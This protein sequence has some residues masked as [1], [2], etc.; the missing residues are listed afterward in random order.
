MK[1]N[2]KGV[3][4]FEMVLLIG[5]IFAVS[6]MIASADFVSGAV[7]P[8]CCEQ[9]TEGGIC[10]D[11]LDP[12]EC[13]SSGK[14][15]AASC[16]ETS[17]C[18]IGCCIDDLEGTFDRNVPQKLCTG[19]N[20]RWVDDPTC[21]IQGSGLGCCVLGSDVEY[22]TS[23]RCSRL[24]DLRGVDK[25]Y[26]NLGENDCLALGELQVKGACV[27]PNDNCKFT[28]AED[29]VSLIGNEQSFYPG[30]LCSAPE[31]NTTCEKTEMTTCLDGQ[32]EVYFLDSC[33]NTA[34][35]YDSSK[36]NDDEYW[37]YFLFRGN[38]CNP[39]E[40]NADS[41]DCGACSRFLGSTCASASSE[42]FNPDMGDYFCKSTSCEYEGTTYENGESWC[43]YDGKIGEGKDVVGSR[44]WKMICSNGEV[45]LEPCA[46]YRNEI[47]VEEDLEGELDVASCKANN[48]RACVD[49]KPGNCNELPDCER[50]TF[51]LDSFSVDVCAPKYPGGFAFDGQY[52]K[53]ANQICSRASKTCVVTYEKPT[54]FSPCTCVEN[55]ECEEAIF[56]QEMND[57][58]IS[59]GDCGGYVNYL[60]KYTSGGYSVSNAPAVAASLYTK[61]AD[62]RNFLG[63]RGEVG[64]ISDYLRA[65][66]IN[67]TSIR[68]IRGMGGISLLSLYRK[69]S[70]QGEIDTVGT[71]NAVAGDDS[72]GGVLTG[73]VVAPITENVIG[74]AADLFTATTPIF[75]DLA[76][77]QAWANINGLPARLNLPGV[78]D[79]LGLQIIQP[80]SSPSPI[81]SGTSGSPTATQ[82]GM[83]SPQTAGMIGGIVGGIIGGIAGNA[84]AGAL[85]LD[86]T[87]SF[88]MS[89]G[90]G[91][92]G[93]VMGTAIGTG[94][95]GQVGVGAA[96]QAAIF[97]G[98]AEIFGSVMAIVNPIMFWVGAGLIIAS[99][100]FGGECEPVIVTYNCKAWRQPAG[101]S[102]CEKCNDGELPCSEYRCESLGAACD[103]INEGTSQEKCVA[104]GENDFKA[105]SLSPQEQV[106]SDNESYSEISEAGFRIV[107]QDGGCIEAYEPIYFGIN[108]NEMARCKFDLQQLDFDEMRF[109]MGGNYFSYNHTTSFLLPDPSHGQARIGGWADG[110]VTLY[111]K[112]EDQ[113]GNQIPSFYEIGM[114]VNDAPD[115]TPPRVRATMPGNG[116]LISYNLTEKEISV[117]TN[118]PADCKW[119]YED[120]EYGFMPNRMTCNNGFEEATVSGYSCTDTIDVNGTSTEIFVRC[121]DQPWLVG[122]NATRRNENSEGYSFVLNKPD[123]PLR[124]VKTAPS[125][126][127]SVESVPAKVDLQVETAGGGELTLC[128]Y[129]FEGYENMIQFFESVNRYHKQQFNLVA[130]EYEIFV[131]CQDETGA[132]VT[133]EVEFEVYKD[134]APPLIARV[135]N[136]GGR[137]NIIT[138]EDS[139][140]VYMN[141][142]CVY[143]FDKAESAGSGKLHTISAKR[144]ER[145]FVKCKDEIGNVPSGCSVIV[146]TN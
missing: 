12:A 70:S 11:V 126:I 92:I 85:G 100:F 142:D 143:D 111:V 94:L 64:D 13:D 87:G 110:E 130:G 91:F 5:M 129:S 132:E 140:C 105:P 138:T 30:Y 10:Q 66:G 86:K 96:I 119:S 58:C 73:E 47:C 107:G 74:P 127:V 101:G 113:W 46:D 84:L 69:L 81:S 112:C 76:S 24:S 55:C 14:A 135:F 4:G 16:S 72:D 124:I 45:Q 59:M 133:K 8:T 144:G 120:V 28:T 44:H 90:F 54:P 36:A 109:D 95:A 51:T 102:D 17:F 83:I 128:K 114:C 80:G 42:G 26:L 93:S 106:I 131:K 145:Y 136:D 62:P 139:Q 123:S 49:S 57:V 98:G 125:A 41:K 31:L 21:S 79:R 25:N 65:A 53:T 77:A 43:V 37:S 146:E 108:T 1:L 60:G 18:E 88:L 67:V 20:S 115:I 97:G 22:V 50:R 122:E 33:G 19:A 75:T 63:Q 9:T 103:L 89:T 82:Q 134:S 23:Q 118:E 40:D 15:V 2:K 7:Q 6:Y 56:T 38:T 29:C 137:I 116:G 35:I 48:W 61:Y 141:D 39:S 121:K 34:N 117:Y 68:D 99:L 52:Q 3:A 104:N 78:A 71:G 27:L 32:D